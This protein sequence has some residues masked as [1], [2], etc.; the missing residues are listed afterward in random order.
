[1]PI[2]MCI[3]MKLH[4]REC[5]MCKQMKDCKKKFDH[6]FCSQ[7]CIR[8]W[9]TC[10]ICGEFSKH[11]LENED[12]WVF[13]SKMCYYVYGITIHPPIERSTKPK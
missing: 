12:S 10:L 2:R 4:I 11:P 3:V 9:N 6:Y 8:M 1:M 13:C 7:K 5:Y